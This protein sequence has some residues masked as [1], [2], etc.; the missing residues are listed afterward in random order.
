MTDKI[1]NYAH[2]TVLLWNVFEIFT[3][4]KKVGE[5][6]ILVEGFVESKLKIFFHWRKR[7]WLQY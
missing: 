1:D 7:D 5:K 2:I 6:C 3:Q 4:R